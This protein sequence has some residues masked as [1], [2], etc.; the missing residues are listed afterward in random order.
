[1]N[2]PPHRLVSSLEDRFRDLESRF[3][4]AYWDSQVEAGPETDRSRTDLEVEL[5]RA[6]G[7]PETF[8]AIK[9][10]RAEP[11]HDPVFARQLE[12]LWLSLM[13][14]QMDE[15][16]RAQIVELSSEVE[17]EFASFRPQLEGQAVS[18]NE[19]EAILKSSPDTERRRAAWEASKQIGAKVADRVRELARLRN[20]AAHDLG[21]ADYYRMSIELQEIPEDWLYGILDEVES[22]THEPFKRWKADLDS[23]LEERFATE[24]LYPWHYSDPFF[25]NAPAA[26]TVNLDA[27]FEGVGAADLARET[28]ARWGIDISGVLARS[29]LYPRDRK[30]QHA[31]CLDVD[32][33]GKDV[34]ILANVVE[35]ERWVE[36][37]LH[38]SGHAAYDISIDPH[39]PYLL[40]RPAHTFVT[41]AI[42]L[43]SG[44]LVH[45]E[46]WL[47]DVAGFDR[48]QVAGMGEGL[49]RAAATQ[50][51]L[52]A[53]WI[54]VMSHF[55]RELYADP[56][57]DLDAR[58]WELVEQLQ[59]VTPPPG[60]SAPDWAA[61]IH[62][63]AA[64][65]YYHNYLLGD[66]LA[67]QLKATVQRECG[68]LAGVEAAG[69]L[70]KERV[71]RP[72][73]LLRWDSLIEGATGR[74]LSAEY[75]AREVSF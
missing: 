34:R 7:D 37:M 64:P 54:L 69:R 22:L 26:G 6:K 48:S 65:V 11:Q 70:L 20:Q 35:G 9:A 53:R 38:E 39:L 67:S 19:I 30:C 62:I 17:S 61:K 73:N 45:D 1:M 14:N 32:R 71:F 36:V 33:S 16:R 56:E 40:R 66:L 4:A 59:L 28:F 24:Q 27:L 74:P 46:S 47:T 18:D 52:M 2:A 63:A 51:L 75:F 44:R 72:G 31:F 23:K 5:R 50:S 43:L 3:H 60:R 58:W 15:E 42:A 25:Q 12:V 13:G 10:A 49:V 57:A 21:F 8:D 55:E 68:G 41:E 29:D